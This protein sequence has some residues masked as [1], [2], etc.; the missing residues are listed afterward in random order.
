MASLK[1]AV[2]VF[3]TQSSEP[4]KKNWNIEIASPAIAIVL[5]TLSLYVTH[6]NSYANM[7]SDPTVIMSSGRVS[8]GNRVIIDDFREAYYWLR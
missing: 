8:D 5:V 7:A 4:T 1:K 2:K 3:D 6:S